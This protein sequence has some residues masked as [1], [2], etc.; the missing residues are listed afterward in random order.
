MHCAV[1]LLSL[2]PWNVSPLTHSRLFTWYAEEEEEEEEDDRGEDATRMKTRKEDKN[3]DGDGN[4]NDDQ[5]GRC[6]E[7]SK[8]PE[9]RMRES[10][11]R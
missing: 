9:M 10:L 4:Q 2:L 6:D 11:R 1:P 3:M 8:P 7:A 5:G